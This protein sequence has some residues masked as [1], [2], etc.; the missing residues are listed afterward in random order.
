[1]GYGVFN[2]NENSGKLDWGVSVMGTLETGMKWNI[3]VKVK[4]AFSAACRD[5]LAEK[6]R[7]RDMQ[8]SD[9]WE[10]DVYDYR[11]PV[12]SAAEAAIT[13]D[14][15]DRVESDIV[16]SSR[17]E[18]IVTDTIIEIAGTEEQEMEISFTLPT[19]ITIDCYKL[20]QIAMT[21]EQKSILDEY[22]K[23][24]P[25]NPQAHIEITGHTCDMGTGEGNLRIGQQRAD[26]AK[27]Y[28]TGKGISSVRI[29]TYSK[30][31]SE[32]VNPNSDEESRTK[33]RRI[34]IKL[35]K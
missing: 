25:E 18:I 22:V 31:D 21:P 26:S 33:N 32:P 29:F 4:L 9:Y 30:G 28:L 3:G 17:P 14:A 34:E 5:L 10:S 15:T 19:A 20:G 35:N 7:Y 2:L 13:N 12:E 8:T 27:G 1:L 11:P 24:L 23:L 6:R 16:L